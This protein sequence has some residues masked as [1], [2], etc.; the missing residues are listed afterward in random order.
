MGKVDQ[1]KPD[2]AMPDLLQPD[3]IISD[4]PIPDL[5]L[6]DQSVMLDKHLPDTTVPDKTVSQDL[7]PLKSSIDDSF[8]EFS[9]GELGESGRKIYISAKGNVQMLDRSDVNGDG[10]ADIVVS[11]HRMGANHVT[12]SYIYWGSASGFKATNRQSLPTVAAGA[13]LTADLNDDGHV[14]VAF[15]NYGTKKLTY[16]INSYIYYG[17][18]KGISATSHDPIPSIGGDKI[19]TADLNRDGYLDIVVSNRHDGTKFSL[20]SYIYYGSKI[21][22]SVTNRSSLPTEGAY[23]LCIADINKDGY[24]DIFFG[25]LQAANSYIYWGGSSGY[26]KTNLD[27][28]LPPALSCSFAD[29][30]KDTALDAVLG[31]TGDNANS[32]I[33]WRKSN[34]YSSTNRTV[35]LTHNAWEVSIADVNQDG[36]LDIGFPNN[37]DGTQH[38]LNSYIYTGSPTGYSSKSKINIPSLGGSGMLFADY[39]AD[40]FVD[41]FMNN[42]RNGSNFDINSYLYHGT[43]AGFGS[44]N[45]TLLPTHGA[46]LSTITDYGSVYNR[47]P[48]QWF[49]SRVHDTSTSNPT[50]SSLMWNAKVPKNTTLKFQLR[51]SATA[52]GISS[53]PWLG[54][55]SS[56]KYYLTTT[57]TSPNPTSYLKGADK[58]NSTHSGNR[59]IQYKAIFDQGYGFTNTPVLDRV[60]IRFHQ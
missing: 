6:P 37:W 42:S 47:V 21:G 55:T 56:M 13:N 19:A 35:L 22:Y 31:V 54:P 51:S 38:A 29:L 23:S 5:P 2:V 48:I 52:A 4:I 17:S 28:S 18:A 25:N 44:S 10:Y 16:Y 39:N 3:K 26:S 49:I 15:A 7:P 32:Y 30:D 8:S 9:K 50:F 57:S 40:G 33:Y 14:D 27:K 11:N 24:L 34:T 46:N 36:H 53:A 60:E 12:D 59:F 20:N 1:T 58:I 43:K 45:R 41:L